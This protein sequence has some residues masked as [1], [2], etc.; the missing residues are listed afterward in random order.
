MILLDANLLL[1]AYT[2]SLP[3]HPAARPWL[4]KTLSGSEPVRIAWVTL[5]AFLRIGTD[6]R[7]FP[8][9]LSAAEAVAI[10]SE[11]LEL[12]GVAILEPSERHWEILS[13][14]LTTTQ[15]HGPLVMDAHLAALA[16]EHGATLYTTDQDFSRFPGLQ[17]MNP[18]KPHGH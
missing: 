15:A 3:H 12:P 16:I 14:L 10:V 7:A 11:W 4:E 17:V 1:Y 8:H 6:S 9:P 18:L 2:P 5:L 13:E